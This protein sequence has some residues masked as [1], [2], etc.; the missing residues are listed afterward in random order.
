MFNF[1]PDD[2]AYVATHYI[3]LDHEQKFTGSG[4]VSY[5]WRDT[6][7]SLD[8]LFGSGLRVALV[9]PD[10]NAIPNGAHLPYYWRFN[11]GTSHVFHLTRAGT[12]MARFDVINVFDRIYRIRNGT[13]VVVGAPQYGPR[14]GLFCGL[15]KSLGA[16]S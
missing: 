1:S 13:G 4:G 11:L 9:L 2:L 6:R 3:D 12:L 16:G 5:L 10:G 15:S 14:R 7:V 8:F